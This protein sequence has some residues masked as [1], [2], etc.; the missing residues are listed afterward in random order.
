MN[1]LAR[2]VIVTAMLVPFALAQDEA[3]PQDDPLPI[4]SNKF[5]PPPPP[6]EVPPMVVK[7]STVTPSQGRNI[8]LIRGE[9]STLQDIPL[10]P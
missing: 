1:S 4:P 10:P 6:R 2:A 5:I 8:T 3:A 7:A 9:A